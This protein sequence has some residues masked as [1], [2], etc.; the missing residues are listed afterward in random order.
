MEEYE[1]EKVND[2]RE[3]GLIQTK[4]YLVEKKDLN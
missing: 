1:L 4:D 2:K 3:G